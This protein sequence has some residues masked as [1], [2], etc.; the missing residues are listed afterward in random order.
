MGSFAENPYGLYDMEGNV[1][2]WCSDWYSASYANAPQ[3]DPQG[4]SAGKARVFRGAFWDLGPQSCR[5]ATRLMSVPNG[6]SFY[7][8][9]RVVVSGPGVE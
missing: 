3:K 6:R 4:P 9:F 1:G 5:S 8:G 7:V 2:Q